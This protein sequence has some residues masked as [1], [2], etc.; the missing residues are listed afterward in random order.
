MSSVKTKI[1][2]LTTPQ[3]IETTIS[4][5]ADFIG[6]VFF[7][8]SPRNLTYQQAKQL[9]QHVPQSIQKVAVTVDMSLTEMEQMVSIFSPDIIQL[10]GHETI[11]HIQ[12]IKNRFAL[13]IIRAFRISNADDITQCMPFVPYIDMILFDAKAPNSSL[14]GGNGLVFDWNLLKGRNFEIPWFL[15]GGLNLQNIENAL[16]ITG[17]PMVDISSSLESSPGIKDPNLIKQFIDKVR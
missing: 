3:A 13:P 4:C 10:H 11:E 5:N 12:E 2:G 7:E 17:A 8:K 16:S 6:C 9:T 14:P 15:S 1:C